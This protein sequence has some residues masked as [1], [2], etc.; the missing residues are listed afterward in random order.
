VAGYIRVKDQDQYRQWIGLEAFL[1]TKFG[2]NYY[3]LDTE[4]GESGAPAYLIVGDKVILIGI[5][6]GYSAEEKLNYCTVITQKMVA[7]LK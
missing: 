6:K 4:V 7:T 5:H 3:N 1:S 2:A